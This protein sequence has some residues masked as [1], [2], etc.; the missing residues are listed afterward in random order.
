MKEKQKTYLALTTE[1]YYS[2]SKTIVPL[3]LFFPGGI[4]FAERAYRGRFQL[5]VVADGLGLGT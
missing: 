1:M 2:N 4:H 5:C 3:L